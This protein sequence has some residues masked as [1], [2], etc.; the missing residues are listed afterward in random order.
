[1]LQGKTL[2]IKTELCGTPTQKS[3]YDWQSDEWLDSSEYRTRIDTC[4]PIWSAS[5]FLVT[6]QTS[7]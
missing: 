1:M 4:T 6:Q 5:K 7:R 3:H 2:L